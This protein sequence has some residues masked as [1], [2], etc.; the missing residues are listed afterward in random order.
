MYPKFLSIFAV[1]CA[2]LLVPTGIFAQCTTSA[3]N[4]GPY[5]P[6]ATIGLFG[7]SGGVGYAWTGPNTFVSIDANPTIANGQTTDSGIYTVVVTFANGC[8]ASST[9]RVTVNPRPNAIASASSSFCSGTLL[10][11]NA[12]GAG[13][14]GNYIWSGPDGFTSA[15]QNP[16]LNNITSAASGSYG[17][18]V[19]NAF[20]CTNT[21]AV[22]IVINTPPVVTITQ[23][24]N[25]C[26]GGSVVLSAS[27]PGALTFDWTGTGGYMAMGPDATV[28]NLTPNSNGYY[29]V[30]VSDVNGCTNTGNTL[31]SV[32]TIVGNATTCIQL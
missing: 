17:V 24:G 7:G 15:L 4:T 19:T 22:S 25:S 16:S 12:V 1:F 18:I 27:A 13:I 28:S 31:V 8:T 6:D 3:T 29:T 20:G 5:C 11:L 32:T 30:L 9:T 26:A 23:A 21:A 14:G 2:A 10:A